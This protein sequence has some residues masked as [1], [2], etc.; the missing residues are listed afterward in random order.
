VIE[1]LLCTDKSLKAKNLLQP[2]SGLSKVSVLGAAGGTFY[3]EFFCRTSFTKKNF[4][5]MKTF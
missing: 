5:P 4:C 3:E 1:G 2:Q